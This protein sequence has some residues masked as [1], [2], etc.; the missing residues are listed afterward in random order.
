[1]LTTVRGAESTPPASL[2]RPSAVG[3]PEQA[4]GFA[5]ALQAHRETR[6]ADRTATEAPRAGAPG[7]AP[8]V[9]ASR[10]AGYLASAAVQKTYWLPG[11]LPTRVAESDRDTTGPAHP[12]PGADRSAPIV[13]AGTVTTAARMSPAWPNG[14]SGALPIHAYPRPAQDNGWGIH[15]VPTVSSSKETVDRFVA[16][17]DEMGI[18]WVT[19]LNEG[20]NIGD[21]DYLVEQLVANGIMPVMRIY[22]PG[23]V[24]LEGDLEA[25]V[26]HYRQL[27]V[28]YYQLYNEPNLVFEN[29]GQQPSV[30]RYLDLWV[31]LARRVIAAGGYPGFGA[32]SPNG[33]VDDRVF[34]ARAIDRLRE[35][36]ELDVLERAWLSVHNYCGGRPL[37]D[38]DG[39][40]RFRQYAEIMAGRLG[41][42]LPMIGTEGGAYVTDV[43]DETTRT[44]LVVDA[45]RYMAQ[46]S[47]PYWFAHS[48]WVVA[49]AEGGGHDPQWEWQ[50]LFTEGNRVSPIVD[51]LKALAERI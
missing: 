6:T 2:Q 19:F 21:N 45:Y 40:L 47:E 22:T 12:L 39:F 20:T 8:L 30:D 29:N 48:Y 13:S 11:R 35:R 4:G 5:E 38:P 17:L 31:P 36:G 42:V 14:T 9:G 41:H 15:W 51:A 26:R 23:L 37:S 27:G 49:N 1:M 46:E 50:A 28:H 3:V 16:E 33:E 10:V 7:A 32:L 44:N 18:S 34:L 25:T 43:V 24:P